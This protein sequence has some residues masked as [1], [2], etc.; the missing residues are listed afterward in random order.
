[1]A[2]RSPRSP[3]CFSMILAISLMY[4]PSGLAVPL[5][6]PHAADRPRIGAAFALLTAAA[7]VLVFAVRV[8]AGFAG[9][10]RSPARCLR[11]LAGF[12]GWALSCRFGP[13][14]VHH[15]LV[16][17]RTCHIVAIRSQNPRC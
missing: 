1:M 15:P 7:E 13:A 9:N 6:M 4:T 14:P 2:S 3:L 5:A 12:F 8:R 11:P 16:E 10:L 17:Q